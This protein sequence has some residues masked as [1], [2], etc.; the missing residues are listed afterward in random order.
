MKR[1]LK[2]LF[3]ALRVIKQDT[4]YILLDRG[5]WP[6]GGMRRYLLLKWYEILL[7]FK[8]DDSNW[9]PMGGRMA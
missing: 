1:T 8:N 9:P 2:S 6:K 5:W 3:E 4:I 7:Y